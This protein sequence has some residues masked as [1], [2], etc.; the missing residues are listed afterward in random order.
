MAITQLSILVGLIKKASNRICYFR[1]F[2]TMPSIE[3][4]LAGVPE[5]N[6]AVRFE[7]LVSGLP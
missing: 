1:R 2:E 4:E 6:R 3:A 7:V 5:D